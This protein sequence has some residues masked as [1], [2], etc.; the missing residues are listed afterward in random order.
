M[1]AHHGAELAS[2]MDAPRSLQEMAR[3]ALVEWD[4]RRSATGRPFVR[5]AAAAFDTYRHRGV[6]RHSAAV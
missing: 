5:A 2:L 6:A 1:V 4:G 3:D